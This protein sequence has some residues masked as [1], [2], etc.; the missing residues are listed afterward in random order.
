MDKQLMKEFLTGCYATP[1]VER[2][3]T[4]REGES[5]YKNQF[6][7]AV[8]GSFAGSIVNGLFVGASSL[9]ACSINEVLYM[10]QN[11]SDL[12]YNNANQHFSVATGLALAVPLVTNV[13]SGIYE[14]VR[15]ARKSRKTTGLNSLLD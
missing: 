10:T 6:R 14:S 12:S 5:Q 7:D 9:I 4:E 3:T 1:T 11:L 13:A 8:V 2:I 15:T